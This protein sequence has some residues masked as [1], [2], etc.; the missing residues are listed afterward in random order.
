M[1]FD[2]YKRLWTGKTIDFDKAYW[3]Q[4]VDLARHFTK[5]VHW[6]EIK[7]FGW[8]AINWWLTGKPFLWLPYARVRNDWI[9]VPPRW[10]IV[11]F[12]ATKDNPYWH[13]AITGKCNANE[14]RVIEQNAISGNGK[15][16]NWDEISVRNYPYQKARVGNCL[17][18]FV[19]YMEF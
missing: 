18:W 19:K 12:G 7:T 4:C 10:A 8:S 3:F 2:D 13:V 1:T 16:K 11:F 9:Q 15:W 5:E 6:K 14:L 17:G